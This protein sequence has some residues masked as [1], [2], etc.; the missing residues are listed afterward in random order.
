MNERVNASITSYVKIPS[1]VCQFHTVNINTLITFLQVLL[2][3]I[4][5]MPFQK[6]IQINFINY[7]HLMIIVFSQEQMSMILFNGNSSLKQYSPM[8][9]IKRGYKLWSK[10]YMDGYLYLFYVYQRK[11]DKQ[12]EPPILQYFELGDRLFIK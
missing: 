8:K 3:L 2:M 7:V 1:R 4:I 9:P 11:S 10:A 6:T 12:H 5:M